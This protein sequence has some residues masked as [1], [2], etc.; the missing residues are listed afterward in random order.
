MNLV[1]MQQ[2]LLHYSSEILEI[3]TE[4]EKIKGRG[5]IKDFRIVK[6][7]SSAPSME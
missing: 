3:I 1:V 7:W 5:E 4:Q 2:S 6:E